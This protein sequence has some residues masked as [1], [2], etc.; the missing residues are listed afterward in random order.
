MN[1]LKHILTGFIFASLYSLFFGLNAT[2]FFIIVFG[3]IPIDFDHIINDIAKGRIKNPKKMLKR[4]YKTADIHTG[5]FHFLHNIEFLIVVF[6]LALYSKI[7]YYLL[8]SFALHIA[9]DYYMKVRHT[10]SFDIKDFSVIL[11]F[12]NR[13]KNKK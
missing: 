4:W 7:F 5:E 12:L 2:A 3:A 13:K 6:L 10:K 8:L 11:H 1:W 9:A